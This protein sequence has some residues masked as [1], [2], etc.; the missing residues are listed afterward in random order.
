[1]QIKLGLKNKFRVSLCFVSGIF[2]RIII[3][4]SLNLLPNYHPIIS[5]FVSRLSSDHLWICFSFTIR[6]SLYLFS[7]YSSDLFPG[8]SSSLYD[9]LSDHFCI[10]HHT[11]HEY[12][13]QKGKMGVVFENSSILLFAIIFIF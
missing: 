13:R 12:S 3:R 8:Y 2:V 11:I 4:T 6:S 7:D 9:S 5:G 1:M 10:I